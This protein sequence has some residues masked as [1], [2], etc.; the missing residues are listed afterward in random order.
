MVQH[1]CAFPGCQ[2][3]SGVLGL[4]RA[5]DRLLVWIDEPGL[6]GRMRIM[7]WDET[8]TGDPIVTSYKDFGPGTVAFPPAGTPWPRACRARYRDTTAPNQA[9]DYFVC[10]DSN[11]F[12]YRWTKGATLAQDTLA[13]K[14]HWQS[15]YRGEVQDCHSFSFPALGSGPKL[16]VVKNSEAFAI[17]EPIP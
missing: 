13:Y 17:V 14:G 8:G 7:K 2:V 10:S 9:G 1:V 11:V 4:A 12:Q 15:A 5:G 16:L 6:G 3:D